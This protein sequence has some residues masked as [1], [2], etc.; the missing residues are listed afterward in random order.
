MVL[1]ET[2]CTSSTPATSSSLLHSLSLMG[3]LKLSIS[4]TR[5]PFCKISTFPSRARP[6]ATFLVGSMKALHLSPWGLSL[7]GISDGQH[8]FGYR[9]ESIVNICVRSSSCPT[10]WEDETLASFSFFCCTFINFGLRAIVSL[11]LSLS[12]KFYLSAVRSSVRSS[13]GKE[14]G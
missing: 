5:F 9:E 4:A 6:L 7:R 3:P 13:M 1:P 12:L 14:R 2:P 11:S 8:V 10:S